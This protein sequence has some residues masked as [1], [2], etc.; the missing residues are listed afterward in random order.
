MTLFDI[1]PNIVLR[2]GNLVK[3][4]SASSS[5][6]DPFADDNTLT[7]L[8]TCK[9]RRRP[10]SLSS[11]LKD[12]NDAASDHTILARSPAPKAPPLQIPDTI[13]YPQGRTRPSLSSCTSDDDAVCHSSTS[14]TFLLQESPIS[15]TSS[16][17]SSSNKPLPPIPASRPTSQVTSM[18][19]RVLPRED[20]MLAELPPAITVDS[21]TAPAEAEACT[22]SN[23][24]IYYTPAAHRLSLMSADYQ[25]SIPEIPGGWQTFDGRR[26]PRP[27]YPF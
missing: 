17:S 19:D 8:P 21:S 25:P 23:E 27:H 20:D 10:D 26:K 14:T 15:P 16:A 6:K 7:V 11:S 1:L 3:R 18:R 5:K 24:S 4:G 9:P 22:D 13:Y 12:F 2:F